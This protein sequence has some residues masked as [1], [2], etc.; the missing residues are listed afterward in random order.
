MEEARRELEVVQ[1]AQQ[2]AGR[3]ALDAGQPMAV[4]L[5][6]DLTAKADDA[7]EEAIALLDQAVIAAGQARPLRA[8]AAYLFR[9]A[10]PDPTRGVGPWVTTA[11]KGDRD[12][13]ILADATRRIA[14]V[15]GR[16]RERQRTL[17]REAEF[18][19]QDARRATHFLPPEAAAFAPGG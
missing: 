3:A 8:E 13:T 11:G 18:A 5:A 12:G 16:R 14:E 6:R 4:G 10:E 17:D 7:E 2:T 19:E 15:Q 9:L 1:R